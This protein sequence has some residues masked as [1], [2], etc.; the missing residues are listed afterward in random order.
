MLKPDVT[1]TSG[2]Q[3]YHVYLIIIFSKKDSH[4]NSDIKGL[5]NS[6]NKKMPTVYTKALLAAR[7]PALFYQLTLHPPA[8]TPQNPFHPC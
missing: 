6:P 3:K 7:F 8:A 1:F 2:F 4:W 5:G